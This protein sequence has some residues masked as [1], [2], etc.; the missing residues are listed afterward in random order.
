MNLTGDRYL[1][2]KLESDRG[3]VPVRKIGALN[4]DRYLSPVRVEKL[5]QR[6]LTGTCP[7]RIRGSVLVIILF[8]MCAN[9]HF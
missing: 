5:V 6:I 1:S 9:P 4:P 2:E 7:L 3:Q 8:N